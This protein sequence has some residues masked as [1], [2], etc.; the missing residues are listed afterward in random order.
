MMFACQDGTVVA[1]TLGFVVVRRV[2]RPL[3]LGPSPDGKDVE[4]AV[5]RPQLLVLRRQVARPRYTPAD[6]ALLAALATGRPLRP[7][8]GL[9]IDS[10]RRLRPARDADFDLESVRRCGTT[11]SA[12]ATD[13]VGPS[14][15]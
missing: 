4:I 3:G 8:A 11:P 5:L 7:H 12:S 6:R 2:L 15:G 13:R 10:S 9:F 1:R 14:S